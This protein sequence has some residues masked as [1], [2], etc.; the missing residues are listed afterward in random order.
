MLLDLLQVTLVFSVG[1]LVVN[2]IS[3]LW[4]RNWKWSLI[5]SV[6]A[7][8]VVFV[9]VYAAMPNKSLSA[10]LHINLV[11]ALLR[12]CSTFQSMVA[13]YYGKKFKRLVNQKANV[14]KP[15]HAMQRSFLL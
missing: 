13:M 10:L 7:F 15:C 5:S 8:I 12:H 11:L 9:F 14:G 6:L 2:A 4:H 3:F 1:W